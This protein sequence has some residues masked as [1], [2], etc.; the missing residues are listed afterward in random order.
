M[1]A[2]SQ[3]FAAAVVLATLVGAATPSVASADG[4]YTW[5]ASDGETHGSQV[6]SSEW[7]PIFIGGAAGFIV[8]GLGGTA[9]DDHQPPV[10]GAL[11]GG[12]YGAIAGGGGGAWLIR[13]SR[14]QDTR[15]A[16]AFTG[17]GVGGGIGAVLFAETISES[18]KATKA[19]GIAALVLLPVMGAFAG[20]SLAMY[21]GSKP[22][23]PEGRPPPP[24]PVAIRPNAT[25]VI[26]GG[27]GTT[28]MTIGFDG[29]F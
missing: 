3:R 21:F 4:S 24:A 17:L 26:T 15:V 23:N 28:G 8:G 14:D 12:G 13:A 2:R 7:L 1:L 11:V 29:S 25:P 22:S 27:L 9:F 19:G 20:R 10:L 16:A 6:A 18:N 5:K